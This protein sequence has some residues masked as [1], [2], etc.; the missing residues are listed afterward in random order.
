[1]SFNPSTF[2]ILKIKTED[3]LKY[4]LIYVKVTIINSLHVNINNVSLMKNNC[5]PRQK[6]KSEKA[7][8]TF[9]PSL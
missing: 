9:L 5:F 3:I 2:S 6:K 4:L 7:L 1:M 8:F